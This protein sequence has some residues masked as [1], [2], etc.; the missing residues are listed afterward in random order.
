MSLFYEF[1]I[2]KHYSKVLQVVS[3]KSSLFP[4]HFSLALHTN[5]NPYQIMQN[6]SIIEEY[7]ERYAPL[8]YVLA[9][10]THSNNVK[11]IETPQTLGWREAKSAVDNCDALIT[12]ISS[13]LLGVLSADCVPILIY[14]SKNHVVSAVHAGWKGTKNKIVIKTLFEMK[15]RYNSNASDMIIGIAPCIHKCCYEV[16]EEVAKNF[17]DMPKSFK[18]K[19]NGKYMLDL[20]YI[21]KQQLLSV[22]VLGQNIE[23]SNV[24]TACQVDSYFSYRKENGCNGRFMSLIGLK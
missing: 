19:E 13:T 6:R 24:C 23:V 18:K 9:N 16:G 1:N 5:Q 21:N 4:Y 20:A 10:Q 3:K 22:G 2:F 7:F 15:K 11:I 8:N 17:S 14:D 12:N